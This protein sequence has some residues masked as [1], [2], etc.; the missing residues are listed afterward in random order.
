MDQRS[1]LRLKD[2]IFVEAKRL[3]DKFKGTAFYCCQ[4]NQCHFPANNVEDF[5]KSLDGDFL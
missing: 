3:A 2:P 5:T 4:D 1:R